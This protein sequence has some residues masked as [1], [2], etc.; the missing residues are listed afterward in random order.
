MVVAPA[1]TPL[2]GDVD[3]IAAAGGVE[4]VDHDGAGGAL[5]AAQ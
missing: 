1:V 2:S 3:E 4:V 5:S